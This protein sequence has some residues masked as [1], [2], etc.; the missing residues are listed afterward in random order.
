MSRVLFAALVLLALISG[1]SA[2][3]G[4]AGGSDE[5][6]R[7]GCRVRTANV[8]PRGIATVVAE[9]SWPVPS[10]AVLAALRDPARLSEAVSSLA[11]MRRLPDGRVLQVHAPGWPF[12]ERQA[13]L[14]WHEE[15]LSGRGVRLE[16]RLSA[17]QEPL[18]K[19]RV[20]TLADDGCWE[21]RPGGAGGTRLSYT[22]RYDAGGAL[23]PWLVRRFQKHGIAASLAELRSAI[24]ST[25][26]VSALES[27]PS[28]DVAAVAAD[29]SP[30]AVDSGDRVTLP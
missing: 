13:T 21:I 23:G 25:G 2:Q 24:E 26:A 16:Y 4:Q 11:E 17:R 20:A 7:A 1:A 22:S 30:P 9:C 27:S 3:A 8:D 15:E 29:F 18:G 14:D 28:P 5:V 12:E 10:E 6:V 19:S